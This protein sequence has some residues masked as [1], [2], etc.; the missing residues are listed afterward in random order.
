M[1]CSKAN[2]YIHLDLDGE[3]SP[4]QSAGLAQ[5]LGQC[6]SCWRLHRDLTLLHAAAAGLRNGHASAFIQTRSLRLADH[7]VRW[8]MVV[9][10]AAALAFA[11]V[12]SKLIKRGPNA[13]ELIARKTIESQGPA[14]AAAP[15]PQRVHVELAANVDSITVRHPT[16]RP[17]ITLMWI[18]PTVKSVQT[19]TDSSE[20]LDPS[21]Q[22]AQS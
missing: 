3:L 14:E 22:G 9:G 11:L 12:A 1:R 20:P 15:I 8:A 21:S 18:Y 13:P 7:R 19:S 5:H 2:R 4:R 6:P 16:H 17:N 10:V